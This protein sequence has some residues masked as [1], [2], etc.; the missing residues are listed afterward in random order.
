MEGDEDDADELPSD[1]DGDGEG[2]A[3][4]RDDMLYGDAGSSFDPSIL[5][6]GRRR[7]GGRKKRRGGP[8][9]VPGE[10]SH[11]HSIDPETIS[12]GP[13]P[14]TRVASR[15]EGVLINQLETSF[16]LLCRPGVR[17]DRHVPESRAP[18][19][20]TPPDTTHVPISEVER[21]A[22]G[23]YGVR[24]M[25]MAQDSL[26]WAFIAMEQDKC[27]AEH[28]ERM[29]VEREL[30]DYK[31]RIAQEEARCAR[32]TW[33]MEGLR[34]CLRRVESQRDRFETQLRECSRGPDVHD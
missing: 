23:Y 32:L 33:D 24:D 19:Y 17:E 3:M 22:R 5:C 2:L 31:S 29:R 14:S 21:M 7:K 20:F 18:L 9:E 1:E 11:R 6:Q 27:R 15:V 34:D 16:Q 30:A 4:E 13:V 12:R 10:S 26:S 25:M 8:T 28:E